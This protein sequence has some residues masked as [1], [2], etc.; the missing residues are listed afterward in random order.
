MKPSATL[1]MKTSVN[2]LF[3]AWLALS[4]I[5]LILVL[6]SIR[7]VFSQEPDVCSE[8]LALTEH[9]K[10]WRF[11]VFLDEKLIGCH[12]YFL[13]DEGETSQ[14]QSIADFEYRLLFI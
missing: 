3:V 12:H 6:T 11:Q 14:L 1:T 8:A 2:K 5:S 9:D 13:E 4:T 10:A 7:P